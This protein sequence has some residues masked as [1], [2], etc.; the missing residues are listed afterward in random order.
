[1]A[2]VSMTPMKL[3]FLMFIPTAYH[4][5]NF[6]CVGINGPPLMMIEVGKKRKDRSEEKEGISD[7]NAEDGDNMIDNNLYIE[8]E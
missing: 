6:M 4:S 2:A 1:V 7:N 5:A 3:R 8:I